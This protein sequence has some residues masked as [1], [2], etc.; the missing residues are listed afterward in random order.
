MLSR[1]SGRNF[2]QIRGIEVVFDPFG[3]SDASVLFSMG[4]TVVFAS[5]SLVNGVPQFLR[6]KGTGWLTAE[7]EM[8]PSASKPRGLRAS[9]SAHRNKRSVE[10]SRLIGRVF[11]SVTDFS[12]FGERTIYIDCDV[13]S[14]DGGTR[15]AAINGASAALFIAANRWANRKIITTNVFPKNIAAISAGVVNGNV[16][17]DL[18]QEEDNEADADFNFVLSHDNEVIEVQGTAERGPVAWNVFEQLKDL[19]ASGC[20]EIIQ[21]LE[22]FQNGL[23]EECLLQSV[24][25]VHGPKCKTPLFCLGNRLAHK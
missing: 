16:F 18:E 5:V 22:T 3:R 10:I 4:R 23:S 12:S 2:D 6:G 24:E 13:L 19:S 9:S 20:K 7:Y 8:L 15:T 14:A 1:N 21:K 17:V 25:T 11:R